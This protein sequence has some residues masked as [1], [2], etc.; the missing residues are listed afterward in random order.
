MRKKA[1]K[2]KHVKRREKKFDKKVSLTCVLPQANIVLNIFRN[3]CKRLV[4]ILCFVFKTTQKESRRHKQ[5]QKHKDKNRY[6]EKGDLRDSTG[7]RQCLGPS[8]VQ[9]ARANSKY[10]SEDCGMKLAAK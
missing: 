6:S 1:V 8:C 7:L 9:A 2:V 10:C 5:K 3:M 4:C